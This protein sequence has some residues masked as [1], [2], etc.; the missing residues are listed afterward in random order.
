M[1]FRIL[2]VFLS[3][4]VGFYRQN[5]ALSIFVD[6]HEIQSEKDRL[7]LQKLFAYVPQ[8]IELYDITV[9]ENVA[10]GID[11]EKIDL[12]LV[13]DCLEKA[14][15]KDFILTL[16]NNVTTKIGEE[17]VKHSGGQRQRIGIARALYRQPA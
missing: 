8:K 6:G 15:M 9:A 1:P 12:D 5:N 11:A 4:E 16:K 13:W 3:T 2:K 17:G 7:A 14:Q 10:F